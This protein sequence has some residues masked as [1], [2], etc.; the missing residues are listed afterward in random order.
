MSGDLKAAAVGAV[1]LLAVPTGLS[2]EE[3]RSLQAEG[4]IARRSARPRNASTGR[5][6]T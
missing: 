3:V 6:V 5:G 1:M 4:V 2:A